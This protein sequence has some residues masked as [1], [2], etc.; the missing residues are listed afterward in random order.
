MPFGA[1][2]LC[3]KISLKDVGISGEKFLRI[4]VDLETKLTEQKGCFLKLMET[5]M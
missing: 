5:E 2:N 1:E 4:S 3:E